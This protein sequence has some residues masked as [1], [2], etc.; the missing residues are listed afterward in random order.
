MM[1]RRRT[2]SRDT[3]HRWEGNPVVTIDDLD[4]KCLDI[5]NA[6]AVMFNSKTLLAIDIEHPTG[7]QSIHLAHEKK[8]GRF[9]VDKEP[10]MTKSADPR[11]QPHES[12]GI[13]DPRITLLEGTYYITYLANGDHGF[14]LGLAKTK[15]FTSV[16]RLGLMS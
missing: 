4:F 8:N 7:M 1:Y 12:W 6:G 16:E 3:V 13:M 2:Y 10:F 11:F 9:E 14:R 5:C 15:D